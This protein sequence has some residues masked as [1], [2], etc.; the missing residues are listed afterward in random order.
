MPLLD[1][2]AVA[3]GSVRQGRARFLTLHVADSHLTFLDVFD[4]PDRGFGW[5]SGTSQNQIHCLGSDH[6]G[7]FR[8]RQNRLEQ[9]QSVAGGS[10]PVAPTIYPKTE[11]RFGSFSQVR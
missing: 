6:A 1:F 10:I 8:I 7:L 2:V 5:E 3:A 9:F 11:R 4:L